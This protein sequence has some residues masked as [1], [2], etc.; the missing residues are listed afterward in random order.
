M[1]D[2]TQNDE[3]F[4]ERLEEMPD[5]EAEQELVTRRLII[6]RE[7]AELVQKRAGNSSKFGQELGIRISQNS[8]Q[9]TLLNDRLK[10]VRQRMDRASW[11]KAVIALYGQEGY[12]ECVAWIMQ[13]EQG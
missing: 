13:E 4:W 2:P 6:V 8:L 5:L 10:E 11:R 9:L 12:E 7:N 1:N 3:I